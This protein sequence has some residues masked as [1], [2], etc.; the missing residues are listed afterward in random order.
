MDLFK[1]LPNTAYEIIGY[2]FVGFVFVFWKFQLYKYVKIEPP[3]S[4]MRSFRWITPLV[5]GIL[6]VSHVALIYVAWK[7]F[8]IIQEIRVLC[9]KVP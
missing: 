2:G 3:E 9:I 7:L 5:L 8:S 6:T 1:F 4:F